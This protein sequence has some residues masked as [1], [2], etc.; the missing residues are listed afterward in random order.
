MD[1]S[2]L[3]FLMIECAT[4]R[5]LL[6]SE[7]ESFRNNSTI[8]HVNDY[9]CYLEFSFQTIAAVS[10]STLLLEAVTRMHSGQTA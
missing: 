5:L 4:R 9:H 1:Q 6:L 2:T 3:S 10:R 7:T 8:S